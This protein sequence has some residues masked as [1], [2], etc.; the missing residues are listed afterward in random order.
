MKKNI[1]L[2][3][4]S[5]VLIIGIFSVSLIKQV[6]VLRRI[7]KEISTQTQELEQLKEKNIKLQAELYRAQ[8]N[9]EYLEKLAR[10]RLGLIK[11]GEQQII[12]NNISE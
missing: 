10:E 3:I 1:N 6:V 2:K 8:G 7:K 5:V 12:T 11:E 9:N 4:I